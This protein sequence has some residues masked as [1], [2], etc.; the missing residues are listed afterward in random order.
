MNK[1]FQYSNLYTDGSYVTLEDVRLNKPIGKFPA[2]TE[3]SGV[4]FDLDTDTVKFQRKGQT[5][6]EGIFEISVG[7]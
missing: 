7:E 4:I 1:L 6:A 5:V 2:G 3:F